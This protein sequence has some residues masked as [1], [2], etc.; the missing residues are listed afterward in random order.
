VAE[1]PDARG[2]VRLGRGVAVGEVRR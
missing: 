2:R 1:C